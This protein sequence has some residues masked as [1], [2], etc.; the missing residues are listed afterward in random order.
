MTDMG[1][2][3]KLDEATKGMAE[4]DPKALGELHD[5]GRQGTKVK[6]GGRAGEVCRRSLS[7]LHVIQQAW[8][9]ALQG[10]HINSRL[11]ST[12]FCIVSS[13]LSSS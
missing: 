10:L 11:N 13:L 5:P 8:A 4:G 3:F 9:Q 12:W 1:I 6:S 2:P 7:E